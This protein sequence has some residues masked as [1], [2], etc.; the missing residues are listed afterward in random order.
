MQYGLVLIGDGGL[1]IMHALF[2]IPLGSCN[3]WMNER[4]M[5]V[6]VIFKTLSRVNRFMYTQ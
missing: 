3:D 4:R 6:L 1:L 2:Y 5:E